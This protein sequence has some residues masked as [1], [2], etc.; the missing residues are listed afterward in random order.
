MNN[1]NPNSLLTKKNLIDPT[2]ILKEETEKEGIDFVIHH[3]IRNFFYNGDVF[4]L[5]TDSKWNSEV[6]QK[7]SVSDTRRHY[8]DEIR[9]INKHNLK[10]II[11]SKDFAN[12]PL[13]KALADTEICN[14][15]GVYTK[16]QFGINVYFF[17]AHYQDKEAVQFF[18]NK[19]Y[20][21]EIIISRVESRL[22]QLNYWAKTT[23]TTENKKLFSGVEKHLIFG[24]KKQEIA[25]SHHIILNTREF[26]FTNK[27]V[28]I[29]D[30]LRISNST[31][32]IAKILSL[33]VKTIEWHMYK[34]RRKIGVCNKSG[35][36]EFAREL[37]KANQF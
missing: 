24:K 11:R 37:E 3:G 6:E 30:I 4:G 31:K 17:T 36:V 20:L 13:L 10:Y 8:Y 21:L 32:N 22:L 2:Q 14:G 9:F 28:Q 25:P 5:T 29:L 16:N 12:T 7:K 23:I 18:I 26:D 34:L 35:I 33:E 15:I 1:L 27:E 19:F